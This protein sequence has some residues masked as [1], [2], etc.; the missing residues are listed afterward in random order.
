M[1]AAEQVA[2]RLLSRHGIIKPPTPVA[3]IAAA[4]DILIVEEPFRD[5]GVSG[6]LVREPDKTIIIV[7]S[8]NAPVRQRFTIA[9]ELGHFTLH[10]GSIYVDGRT[11]VNFR[12]GLSSMATDDEEISANAFAAA[13]LMPAAWVRQ[14]FE[15]VVRNNV[16]NSEKNLADI[17]ATHFGVS[18]QAMLFRLLNLGLLA[19]P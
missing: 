5:D 10:A 12:D 14:D 16:I 17:L 1:L 4:E 7:N 8:A 9:H 19:A 3:E 18:G 6:V 11:R 2:S 15:N 13:L